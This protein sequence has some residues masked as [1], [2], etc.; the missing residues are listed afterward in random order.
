MQAHRFRL[1]TQAAA[2]VLFSTLLALLAGTLLHDGPG[3]AS[4]ARSYQ[5]DYPVE[6]VP[7]DDSGYPFMDPTNTSEPTSAFPSPTSAQPTSAFPSPTSGEP[8]SPGA[9]LTATFTATVPP[10]VFLTEN[11]EQEGSLATLAATEP[12]GGTLTPLSTAT[13]TGVTPQPVRAAQEE[14]REGIAVDW[15][16]FWIGFSLPVLSA[17]GYVLY[18]LDRRP[19]LFRRR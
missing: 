9:D 12:P 8:T 4:T 15:G 11:A 5:D 7:I 1:L 3:T 6:T 10:N 14:A 13:V 17:S 19:D 16:L 18:L 2:V